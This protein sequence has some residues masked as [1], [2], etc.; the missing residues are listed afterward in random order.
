MVA[1]PLQAEKIQFLCNPAY[2]YLRYFNIQQGMSTRE[3][4]PPSPSETNSLL[5][6]SFSSDSNLV[7]SLR[8]EVSSV[9]SDEQEA[10]WNSQ[11]GFSQVTLRGVGPRCDVARTSSFSNENPPNDSTEHYSDDFCPMNLGN[12]WRKFSLY[13]IISLEESTRNPFE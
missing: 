11:E 10:F 5:Q 3:V 7:H 8:G 6:S 4:L 9:E 12:S 1:I 2:R 13:P